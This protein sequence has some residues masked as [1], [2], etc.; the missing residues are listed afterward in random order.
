MLDFEDLKGQ[1]TSQGRGVLRG[2]L[3]E[4][5]Q[6]DPRLQVEGVEPETCIPLISSG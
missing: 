5:A 3:L 2:P 6:Q 1:E 4:R